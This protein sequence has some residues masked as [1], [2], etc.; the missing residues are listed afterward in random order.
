MQFPIK[1]GIASFSVEDIVVYKPVLLSCS[2]GV[3]DEILIISGA[4]LWIMI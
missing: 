2:I 3:T 4:L 1:E